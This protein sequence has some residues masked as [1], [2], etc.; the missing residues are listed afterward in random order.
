MILS[1]R[2]F[3]D[4]QNLSKI[5]G[6]LYKFNISIITFLIIC[7]WFFLLSLLSERFMQNTI[8]VCFKSIELVFIEQ[9]L[10]FSKRKS[11][12]NLRRQ[13]KNMT[14]VSARKI[15]LWIMFCETYK[16]QSWSIIETLIFSRI[17]EFKVFLKFIRRSAEWSL[18]T[19]N[20]KFELHF[21]N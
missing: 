9:S 14:Y 12:F 16:V 11:L 10:L 15:V 20:F 17:E 3:N 13:S 7:L 1:N 5:Y 4:L 19:L 6:K 21:V 8:F 18:Q 2:K